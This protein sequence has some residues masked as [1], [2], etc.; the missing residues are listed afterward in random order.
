MRA[1]FLPL[2]KNIKLTIFTLVAFC[3]RRGPGTV[4]IEQILNM[5]DESL[6]SQAI[7]SAAGQPVSLGGAQA[8]CHLRY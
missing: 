7:A 6:D 2:E 3:A 8:Q 5:G 1:V 4:S